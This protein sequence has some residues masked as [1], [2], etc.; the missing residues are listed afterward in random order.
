MNHLMYLLICLPKRKMH[1][2]N[3]LTLNATNKQS[4]TLSRFP[5]D[6][7]ENGTKNAAFLM[8]EPVPSAS[9]VED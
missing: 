3:S 9:G 2:S 6:T 5:Q 4:A 8:G 7:K 1:L